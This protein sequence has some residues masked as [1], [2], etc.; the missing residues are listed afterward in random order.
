MEWWYR[1]CLGLPARTEDLEEIRAALPEILDESWEPSEEVRARP[2][3][4]LAPFPGLAGDVRAWLEKSEVDDSQ[5]HG[6]GPE[7]CPAANCP[8]S[9]QSHGDQNSPVSGQISY[10]MKAGG[11]PG[12]NPPLEDFLDLVRQVHSESD[13]VKE[14]ILTDRYIYDDAGEDGE[15]GGHCN[16]I[17]YLNVLGI[18][19]S[20]SFTLKINPNPKHETEEKKSL[21]EKH[22][23]QQYDKISFDT[24]SPRYVFHDRFYLVRDGEGILDGLFGPSL[25]GLSSNHIALVGKIDQQWALDRLDKWL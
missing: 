13:G 14:V 10:L 22:L 3:W 4:P 23:K 18:R 15:G 20:T 16:L 25:N 19:R 21:F 12:R 5:G 8:K 6:S 11:G 17:Q 7:E 1:F 2:A 9:S 24:F